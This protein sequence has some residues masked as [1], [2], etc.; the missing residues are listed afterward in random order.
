VK[1]LHPVLTRLCSAI[2]LFL[3]AI[4]MCWNVGQ[5]LEGKVDR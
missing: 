1:P 5:K 2:P 4:A 3:Q